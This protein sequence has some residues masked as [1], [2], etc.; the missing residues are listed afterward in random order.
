MTEP[1]ARLPNETLKAYGAFRVY[2]ELGPKRNIR[3]VAQ[4]LGKSGS[5]IGRWSSVHSWVERVTAFEARA[6]ARVDDV[7]LDALAK[8]AKRQAEIAQLHGEASALVAREVVQRIATAAETNADP[9]AGMTL[10]DVLRLEATMG[11]M[12]N[13]AVLTERLALGMT[14]DQGAEPVPRE[15]AEDL[16]RR[17]TDEELDARLAG[18]D[19][20]SERRE[21]KRAHRQSA[22]G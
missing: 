15:Q 20:L 11:R 17:L 2:L 12:H 16:A 21:L 1:G 6:T 10:D 13:R 18:V 7:H 19:E 4:E 14:T 8:R 5:L 9:F 22:A 3:Q